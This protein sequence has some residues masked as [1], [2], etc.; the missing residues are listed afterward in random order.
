MNHRRI[1]LSLIAVTLTVAG[2]SSGKVKLPEMSNEDADVSLPVPLPAPRNGSDV[3]EGTV[4]FPGRPGQERLTPIGRGKVLSDDRLRTE[5]FASIVDDSA[6]DPFQFHYRVEDGNVKILGRGSERQKVRVG[7][8][9]SRVRGVREVKNEVEVRSGERT[10]PDQGFSFPAPVIRSD[11]EIERA[12]Q[13]EIEKAPRADF[14]RVVIQCSEGVVVL[15]GGVPNLRTKLAMEAAASA[16][17]GVHRVFNRLHVKTF[18]VRSDERLE[19]DARAALALDPLLGSEGFQ[20]KA[21]RGVV[22]IRGKVG[23]AWKKD[24]AARMLSEV[25][26][27]REIK[28][29][30]QISAFS[31]Q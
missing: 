6:T 16:V 23:A 2:C 13:E 14:S 4:F 20:V 5:V 15:R 26:G 28:N 21:R 31:T 19:R 11:E 1:V 17:Q 29:L 12:V 22:E 10:E 3:K 25:W 18:R 7:E 27:V 8:T 9:I 24:L 30:L